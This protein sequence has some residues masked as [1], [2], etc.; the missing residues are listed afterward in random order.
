MSPNDTVRG[1]GKKPDPLTTTSVPPT[2]GPAG[3]VAPITPSAGG[4]VSGWN[5]SADRKI[6]SSQHIPPATSTVP[7]NSAVAVWAWRPSRSDGAGDHEAEEG[8]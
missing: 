6:W 8:S 3:G 7:S 1:P 5:S 2:V 4:I